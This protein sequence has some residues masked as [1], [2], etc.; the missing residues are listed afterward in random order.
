MRTIRLS[1]FKNFS[2]NQISVKYRVTLKTAREWRSDFK[3]FKKDVLKHAKQNGVRLA[4]TK[5]KM[6]KTTIYQW[7]TKERKA[8]R[9]V[10]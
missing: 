2:S 6:N 5:F 10:K 9:H 7:M 4:A 8:K 3:K 1:D